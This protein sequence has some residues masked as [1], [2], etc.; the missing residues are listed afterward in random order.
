MGRGSQSVQEM[1]A[2][3]RVLLPVHTHV[4]CVSL[5]VDV[6]A[7]GWEGACFYTCGHRFTCAFVLCVCA[8]VSMNL[9]HMCP[10]VCCGCVGQG[11][12]VHV[13]ICAGLVSS[14]VHV[15]ACTAHT[16]VEIRMCVSTVMSTQAQC[17]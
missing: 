10:C 1:K 4:T 2:C 3:S 14:C 15:W 7:C 9:R 12:C 17:L 13:D 6:R 11:E 16:H 5:H 8:C